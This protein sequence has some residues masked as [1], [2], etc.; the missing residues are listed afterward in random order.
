MKVWARTL[1]VRLGV[2]TGLWVSAGL[3]IAWLWTT[4]I[5]ADGLERVFEARLTNLLD[6]LAA[7][8]AVQ[9]GTVVLLRPVSEPRFEQ[10]LSG[11]YYQI[12]GLNGALLTSRSLWDSQLQPVRIN[13]P[14]IVTTDIPGP[15]GQRLRVM[16]RDFRLP[17]TAGPIHVQ[18]A[19]DRGETI[20]EI[21]RMRRLLAIACGLLGAG[22]V[23]GVV[24]LVS[25]SL[26]RL[27]RLSDSVADLRS[28][29]R[30]RFD[31]TVPVEVQPLVAEIDAL[32][33]Q[34]RATVDRARG[35][36]GNLAHALRTRLSVM[37]NA[38]ELGD[39]AAVA[40]EITQ[41]ERLVQHHLARARAASLSGTAGADVAVLA[42]AGEIRRALLVLFAERGLEIGVEGNADS[43]V[44]CEREDLAEM[45]GNL[46]ENGCK[47]ARHR[48][49]VTVRQ[50]ANRVLATVSDDGPGLSPAQLAEVMNRGARADESVPG[51]GLGLSIT[52]EL[53]SLYGG[54]LALRSPGPEGGLEACLSL[55]AS[56]SP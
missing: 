52:A 31:L 38:L 45:L 47:W 41:A 53:A 8:I 51:S 14:R 48:V 15:M 16:E 42:T 4:Q 10:P 19:L 12:Q 55:P 9:D 21:A 30:D 56:K 40:D 46:M 17:D 44:R 49:R 27:R 32:V 23:G 3:F 35:H 50:E 22:L 5:V 6:A 11:A 33:R 2:L 29:A 37:R 13:H 20:E 24:L 34:N 26:S 28:G 39:S 7:A 54:Q 18:V 25:A 36:V 43:R 1:T